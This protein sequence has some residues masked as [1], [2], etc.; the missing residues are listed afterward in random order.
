MTY[1]AGTK[2]EGEVAITIE[3]FIWDFV[4]MSWVLR[5]SADSGVVF[6]SNRDT[7]PRSLSGAEKAQQLSTLTTI[8]R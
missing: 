2:I 7:P 3:N 6:I 5:Q 1:E 8:S 4:E